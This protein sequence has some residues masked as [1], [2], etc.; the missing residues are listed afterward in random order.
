[1]KLNTYKTLSVATVDV[2]LLDLGVI[3]SSLKN[4]NRMGVHIPINII[5]R[6]KL[7]KSYTQGVHK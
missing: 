1:M 2:M 5:G 6:D 7:T 3:F 4:D